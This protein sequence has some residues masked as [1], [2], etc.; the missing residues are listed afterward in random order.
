MDNKQLENAVDD[1]EMQTRSIAE[2]LANLNI[3]LSNTVGQTEDQGAIDWYRQRFEMLYAD[4][5]PDAMNSYLRKAQR[6][7]NLNDITRVMILKEATSVMCK[8]A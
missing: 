8:D 3:D 5:V 4:G 6:D 7:P 1:M 2:G